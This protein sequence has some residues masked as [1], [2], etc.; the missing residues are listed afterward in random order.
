LVESL[1][2]LNIQSFN[3]IILCLSYSFEIDGLVYIGK[4]MW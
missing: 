3:L 1:T 4:I 2:L